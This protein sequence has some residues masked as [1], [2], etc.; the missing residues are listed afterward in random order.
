VAWGREGGVHEWL[1]V[2]A[3]QVHQLGG[4]LQVHRRLHASTVSSSGGPQFRLASARPRA[5]GSGEGSNRAADDRRPRWWGGKQGGGGDSK[6]CRLISRR[7]G[8][9]G[10]PPLRG[11]ELK[12]K[13]HHGVGSRARVL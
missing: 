8:G 3:R 11:Q 1:C 9:G 12:E 4:D 13:L 5:S 6:R 2:E 7:C 10:W